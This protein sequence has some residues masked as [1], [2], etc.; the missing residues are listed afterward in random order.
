MPPLSPSATSISTS[1]PLLPARSRSR[2][3][4]AVLLPCLAAGPAAPLAAQQVDA[5]TVVEMVARLPTTSRALVITARPEQEPTGLVAWLHLAAGAEVAVL[6]LHRGEASGNRFGREIGEALGV[7]RVQEMQEVRRRAG[8][9]QYFT[10]GYDLGALAPGADPWQVWP[11]QRILADLVTV[12]RSVRPHIL[13]VGCAAPGGVPDPE[14]AVARELAEEAFAASADT[15]QV[16]YEAGYFRP[17]W[18]PLHLYEEGCDGQPTVRVDLAAWHQPRAATFAAIGAQASALQRSQGLGLLP[19]PPSPEARLGLIRSLHLD[20]ERRGELFPGIRTTWG[21]W[22]RDSSLAAERRERAAA[23][24][25]A[26]AAIQDSIDAGSPAEALPE[27]LDAIGAVRAARALVV[28]S[29][30]R[31]LPWREE[32]A[33]QD[34]ALGL[35]E[36]RLVEL[37]LVAAGIEARWEAERGWV[38]PG[39]SLPTRLTIANRGMLPVTMLGGQV[40]H[41][42]LHQLRPAAGTEVIAP[43]AEG[44]WDLVLR[45]LDATVPWWLALRREELSYVYPPARH[46][47]AALLGGEGSALHGRATVRLLVGGVELPLATDPIST[48]LLDPDRG[49]VREPVLVLPAITVLLERMLDYVPADQF[50]GRRLRVELRSWTTRPREVE[51]RLQTPDG[52]TVPSGTRKL[53]LAP[54]EIAE[55]EFD[56]GVL[57]SRERHAI[58][59]YAESEGETFVQGVIPIRHPHIAP[60]AMYRPSGLWLD[61]IPV[62]VPGSTEFGYLAG[63]RDFGNTALRQL[64]LR[65]TDLVPADLDSARLEGMRRIVVGP[66]ALSPAEAR[67][68]APA[69]LAWVG[70]GGRLVVHDG[71]L[72]L[73]AS[74]LLPWP[75]RLDPAPRSIRPTGAWLS[76]APGAERWWRSPHRL[77][78]ADLDDWHEPAGLLAVG[79]WDPRYLPIAVVRE[80]PDGAEVPVAW[81]TRLGRGSVV[82]T[83]LHLPTQVL[84]GEGGALRLLLNFLLAPDG[85]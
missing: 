22:A 25:Q 9:R 35:T 76:P 64:L 82:Y 58:R 31:R 44:A 1:R 71:G 41:G 49:A 27:V 32:E 65:V 12:I 81:S 6:S 3:L 15:S 45:P 29:G 21:E 55:V 69:L 79:E 20:A 43:G 60:I 28:P 85:S 83:T 75:I 7:L 84:A 30:D 24:A 47:P 77:D 53:T 17:A 48:V 51:V 5:T 4:L 78:E 42:R 66:G 54:G 57:L 50:S 39:D 36:A 23:L 62:S 68:V 18:Q 2:A 61:A 38:A 16:S 72:E 26:I 8:G 34:A 52:V 33:E 10:R 70:R 46:P 73:L 19:L 40:E 59:V 80:G 74:G 63:P 11:R 67:R 56:L 37:A 13:V 14:R